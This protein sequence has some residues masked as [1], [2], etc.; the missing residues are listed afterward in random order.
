MK[1]Q[2]L[3]SFFSVQKRKSGSDESD[4]VSKENFP[5]NQIRVVHKRT[6]LQAVAI[7]NITSVVG[8][9]DGYT[10]VS[11]ELQDG[12]DENVYRCQ[13]GLMV[14]GLHP[15]GSQEKSSVLE[16]DPI[17]DD[18][19]KCDTESCL[20]SR[21]KYHVKNKNISSFLKS[22]SIG[23]SGISK[24]GFVD[25]AIKFAH[26]SRLG[27]CKSVSLSSLQHARVD[28]Q[29]FHAPITC[30]NFD[31]GGIL[32]ACAN[33]RGTIS[34]YDFD[35]VNHRDLVYWNN[36]RKS[37]KTGNGTEGQAKHNIDSHSRISSSSP[38][39]DI[40][41]PARNRKDHPK[42]NVGPIIRFRVQS[43][44]CCLRPSLI[45]W[46]PLNEDQLAISFA[47]HEVVRLYDIGQLASSTASRPS[48]IRIG[49]S[50]D[51]GS[52]GV[53]HF[54]FVV[55]A[56][57]R[58]NT[59][60]RAT[61][62]IVGYTNGTIR[63]WSYSTSIAS[64]YRKP[65]HMIWAFDALKSSGTESIADIC[66]LG[67]DDRRTKLENKVLLRN[68]CA[69]LLF[70]CGKKGSMLLVDFHKCTK[71]AFSS[72]LTPSPVRN[73]SLSKMQLKICGRPVRLR[74]VMMSGIQQVSI[75][76]KSTPPRKYQNV[77]NCS[78]DKIIQ[79]LLEENFFLIQTV[80]GCVMTME[81]ISRNRKSKMTGSTKLVAQSTLY[82]L[83]K[84]D[85]SQ[86]SY[87]RLLCRMK[88]S[89]VFCLAARSPLMANTEPRNEEKLNGDRHDP[90]E[91]Y[92]RGPNQLSIIEMM[93]ATKQIAPPQTSVILK[94]D[95][96]AL[97][98]HPIHDWVITGYTN[99]NLEILSLRRGSSRRKKI[100]D[101]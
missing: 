97:A 85:Q 42:V 31:S 29:D 51:R 84:L 32:L 44:N 8:T 52:V 20:L 13:A 61:R 45:K 100:C 99:G 35:Q 41:V 83:H 1:Q 5:S 62:M 98:I 78:R 18:D 80:C 48:Y 77:Q 66:L 25:G 57:K 24:Q 21:Y 4:D 94:G 55:M 93:P 9:D 33:D 19:A 69:G 74:E 91:T 73:W 34:V 14:V 7:E 76:S 30:L 96:S 92:S 56:V 58:N 10:N 71:K 87:K 40:R 88:D 39:D 47:N 64:E 95:P 90:D 70:V 17:P 72:S 86:Q 23:I 75:W 38:S 22:R 36:R 16:E 49:K 12:H 67:G 28:S 15:Q 59:L 11:S 2:K 101:K 89:G 79:K 63:L 46:N 65:S 3:Q 82:F 54:L 27:I 6:K 81:T 43:E 68:P 37:V 26:K 53:S 50:L 60:N